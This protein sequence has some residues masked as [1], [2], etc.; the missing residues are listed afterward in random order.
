MELP[1]V[2]AEALTLV[3]LGSFVPAVIQ[4]SWLARHELI[5]ASEADAA[6]LTVVSADFTQ[7]RTEWFT[8]DVFQDRLQVSSGLAAWCLSALQ[9][10][11]HRLPAK[12]L[13]G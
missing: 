6:D 11:L 9:R 3:C 10:S 2:E 4:P 5:P 1:E 8:I 7:F 13:F 12:R